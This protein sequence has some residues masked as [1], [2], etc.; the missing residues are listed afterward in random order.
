MFI[1]AQSA[2]VNSHQI[3]FLPRVEIKNY[4]AEIDRRNFYDK[5]I[6]NQ[7]TNNLIKQYDKIKKISTGQGDGYTTGCLF[8]FSYFKNSYTLV[9]GDLSKEKVLDTENSTDYF[10]WKSK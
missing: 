8:D 10:Y 3:Y 7:E 9:V 5:A 4:N 2:A 6:H 1:F